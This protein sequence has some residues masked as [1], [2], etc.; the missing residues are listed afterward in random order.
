MLA[1][2]FDK[3]R[4]PETDRRGLRGLALRERTPNT[5]EMEF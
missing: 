5:I 1:R 4:D 2:G 3:W